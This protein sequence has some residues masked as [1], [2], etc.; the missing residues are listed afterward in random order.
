MLSRLW[1]GNLGKNWVSDGSC[2]D[3][4][5]QYEQH[6]IEEGQNLPEHDHQVQIS[7]IIYLIIIIIYTDHSETASSEFVEMRYHFFLKNGRQWKVLLEEIHG[8]LPSCCSYLCNLIHY[9]CNCVRLC[10]CA[11]LHW[12]H[13]LSWIHCQG[14]R[15]LPRKQKDPS[16]QMVQMCLLYLKQ[17]PEHEC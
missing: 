9:Q 6:Q 12:L 17:I 7:N 2:S 11:G 1:I 10:V 5:A 8:Q 14:V 13:S 3:S 15:G 16:P 4:K